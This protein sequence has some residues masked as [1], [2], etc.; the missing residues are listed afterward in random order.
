MKFNIDSPPDQQTSPA[1]PGLK[2]L[3]QEMGFTDKTPEYQAC[4]NFLE[5][6]RPKN[7]EKTTDEIIDLIS[8]DDSPNKMEFPYV[9]TKQGG[10][11]QT[12]NTF[13]KATQEE[14]EKLEDDNNNE[15]ARELEK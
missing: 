15:E 13:N 9:E 14:Y 8:S 3:I 6:I 11:K 1:K 10:G 7:K 12:D 2:A 4:M 5:A